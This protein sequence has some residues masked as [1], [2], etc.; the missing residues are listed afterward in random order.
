M[1]TTTNEPATPLPWAGSSRLQLRA[2]RIVP[3]VGT[4]LVGMIVALP[5]FL[6]LLNSFNQAGPAD[7]PAYGLKNWI[8]AFANSTTASSLWN[9][10]ALGATRTA[11]SLALGITVAWLIA[12]SDMPGR[13]AIEFLCWIGFFL[14]TLPLT[15]GWILLLDPQYGLINTTL[16]KLPFVEG[17]IFN[18]YS[19]WGIIWVHLASS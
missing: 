6:L 13:T 8:E 3:L 5:P 19:F 4:L 15:F 14:P 10:V 2:R 12:R 11:I 7:P 17:S 1:A 9:T 16:D 18:I